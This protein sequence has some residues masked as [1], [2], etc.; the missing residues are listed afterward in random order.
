MNMDKEYPLFPELSEEAGIAAQELINRFKT[1]MTKVANE[2]IKDFYC[3]V[4]HYIEEDSWSN[5]R[6]ELMDGFRDYNNRKIQGEYDFKDI[7]QTILKNHRDE[8]IE[9]LN[10]DMLAEI[11]SLKK[12]L[13][14]QRKV[15]DRW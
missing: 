3:D 9:D 5:F 13:E 8:I 15:N 10:S 14:F 1:E 12:Q 11:E 7:R 4:V 6:N 2:V